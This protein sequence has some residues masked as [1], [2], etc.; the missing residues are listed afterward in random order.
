MGRKA[1]SGAQAVQAARESTRRDPNLMPPQARG[2][3]CEESASDQ[4]VAA[5]PRSSLTSARAR[6]SRIPRG[7][8]RKSRSARVSPT[9]VALRT[10]SISSRPTCAYT[11]ETSASQRLESRGVRSGTGTITR[12]SPRSRAYSRM[13]SP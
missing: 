1:R 10:P 7:R 2:L 6:T 8:T 3:R 4:R 9:T 12:L 11:G 5:N 13:S